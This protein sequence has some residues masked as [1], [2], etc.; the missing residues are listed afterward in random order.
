MLQTDVG[1]FLET[2]DSDAMEKL[3]ERYIHDFIRSVHKSTRTSP[4]YAEMEYEVKH[5][6]CCNC[7]LHD[8]FL[9]NICVLSSLQLICTALAGIC[10]EFLPAMSASLTRRVVA[11]HIVYNR[12]KQEIHWFRELAS[13]VPTILLGLK[14]K[15]MTPSNQMVNFGYIS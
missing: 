3:Q 13:H 1:Q 7:L 12:I 8:E 5:L 10:K 6:K 9:L 4:G 2:V 11:V 15:I 14:K